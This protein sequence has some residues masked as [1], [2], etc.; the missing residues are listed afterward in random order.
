MSR[1]DHLIGA[2]L[3]VLHASGA[4]ALELE[5]GVTHEELTNDRPDWDSVYVEG[6]HDFAPRQT[7]YGVVREVDRFDL[8]D[9]EIGVAYY[10][11]FG[12]SWTG[13]FE[14]SYS[15]DHNVLAETSVLGQFAW[16]IGGGWVVSGGAR[17]N[18]Y[19]DTGTRLLLAGVERY[20]GSYRVAY[21]AYNGKPDGASSAPSHR[22]AFDRYYFDER[23]RI[24]VS[25]AWGSE[26]ENVGPPTGVIVTEIRAI[27]VVGRHW[28]TPKWALAWEVGTHE[29]GDYYRRGGGRLGLRYS[30]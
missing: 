4:A 23:S 22:L 8:R 17:F 7:L 24:G 1:G 15:P 26:V 13:Q 20:F 28:L 29:Q 2:L 12:A 11:P 21:T 25:V 19:T 5:G 16:A 30:F 10:Q 18:E 14:A 3:L 6:A 27:T 9:T